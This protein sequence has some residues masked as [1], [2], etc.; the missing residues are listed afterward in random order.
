MYVGAALL[1]G[2][3]AYG[4]SIF[5]YIRAQRDLGAAKTSAYYA[6]APFLGVAFSLILFKGRPNLQFF[7]ALAI[8]II[9]TYF[10]VTDTIVL[11]HTH[12]H[13]HLHMHE[14]QHDGITH[15]HEHTHVH[16]HL[17]THK[18][19]TESE[20]IHTHTKNDTHEHVH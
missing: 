8:M 18:N 10:S 20:H 19:A 12:S 17:H 11:Q 7:I 14:H 4:L 13:A 2:F 3:A 16:T 1:L 5:F 15:V 9:G 6:V